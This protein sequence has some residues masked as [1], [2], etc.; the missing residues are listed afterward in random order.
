MRVRASVVDIGSYV[1]K[2]ADKFVVDTNVWLPLTYTT[3]GQVNVANHRTADASYEQFVKQALNSGCTLHWSPTSFCEIAHTIERTERD[4]YNATQR[5][6]VGQKTYRHERDRERVR[7]I[8]ATKAAW[9]L[10]TNM[11]TGIALNLDDVAMADL[12][13][14]FNVRRVDAYDQFFITAMQQASVLNVLTNDKDFVTVPGICVMT[15]DP[16]ALAAAGAESKLA[17]TLI[18]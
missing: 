11:A 15:S 7:V 3:I 4:L 13:I 5:N 14:D 2:E 9:R 8:T 10:V 16:S 18:A 6:A 1:P 12:A 17:T